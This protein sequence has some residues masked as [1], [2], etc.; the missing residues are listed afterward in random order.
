MVG[1]KKG[2]GTTKHC[3]RTQEGRPPRMTVVPRV[4]LGEKQRE[5]LDGLTGFHP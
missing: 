1:S 5:E 3:G 2:K 4:E